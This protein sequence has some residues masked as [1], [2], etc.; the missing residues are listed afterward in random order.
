ME[1]VQVTNEFA[2]ERKLS[3]A[4]SMDNACD[5]QQRS[6]LLVDVSGLGPGTLS[7]QRSTT[8]NPDVDYSAHQTNP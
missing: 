1:Q 6:D 8:P 3:L 4:E 7:L 2:E 5:R